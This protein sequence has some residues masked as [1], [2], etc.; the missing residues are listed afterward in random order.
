VIKIVFFG[1][2]AESALVLEK[3]IEVGLE[4]IAVVT[5]PDSPRGRGQKLEAPAVKMLA[6]QHGITILQ[7]EQLSADNI[8][9]ADIGILVSYGK[10]IP[11]SVIDL[12]PHGIINVHPSLLPKYRGPSPIEAAIANGDSKTG[13]SLM[14]LSAEMDAGPVYAQEKIVL[15]GTET[16]PTLY[17][18]LFTVG[19]E[20]LINNINEI[21]SGGLKPTP[22]DDTHATYTKLITKADGLLDPTTMTA[23]E[24][25]RKVRAYLGFPKTRL[26]FHGQEV[27]ITA[28]KALPGFAGD[29][30]PDVI[31]CKDKT[32]LQIIELISPNSGKQMKISD[33]LNGLKRQS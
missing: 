32:T 27:I 22:Q 17:E 1:T 14:A 24:C 33:Y 11:Q 8:P 15:D 18:K 31:I 21:V 20:M 30:W 13:V 7:P 4:I 6:E 16:K 25:E 2:E 26:N 9:Q 12:F 5:K 19:S 10:I 29:E 23:D 28:A 3:L